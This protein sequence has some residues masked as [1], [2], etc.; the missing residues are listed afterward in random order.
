MIRSLLA[1][2]LFILLSSCLGYRTGMGSHVSCYQTISIPY[3]QGD[4]DGSL[5]AELVRAFSRNGALSYCPSGGN[6]Y[7]HAT[8]IECTKENIGYRYQRKRS[9]KLTKSIIPIESR[10]KATVEISLLDREKNCLVMGP[11]RILATVDFDHDYYFSRNEINIFSLGQLSDVDTAQDA[12]L[13]PLNVKLAQKIVD[14]VIS[15]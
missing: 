15:F 8:I 3:I 7:L 12:A 14:A 5:T 10:L 1:C 11:S 13:H 2:T 9:G 4:S 6:L